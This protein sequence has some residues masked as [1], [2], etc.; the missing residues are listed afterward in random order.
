MARK[1][2]PATPVTDPLLTEARARAAAASARLRDAEH[3]DPS[4]DTWAAEYEAAAT[5][6][7]AA[8]RR[9]EALEQLRASQLERAGQ[10][11]A[12]LKTA[13]PELKRIASGLAAARDAVAAAA[14]AHFKALVA[15]G[16]AVEQYNTA[17]AA[18][19]ARVAGFGLRVRDDLADGGADHTEG[20]LDPSALR[21]EGT[22]WT[23]IPP[24]GV[25]AHALRQVFANHGAMHPLGEIGKY[26]WRSFE[27]EARP[28][29]LQVPSVAEA[30]APKAPRPVVARPAQLADLKSPPQDVPADVNVSGYE[31]APAPRRGRAAR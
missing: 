31:P 5:A 3:A 1:Y 15:L 22:T 29:Q 12:A 23:P 20:I 13:A 16:A 14:D 17:L 7:R 2:V 28:D 4:R 10:R 24:G 8:S 9:V 21:A 11:D 27:V 19:R 26:R 30:V 6:A 18:G 25:E